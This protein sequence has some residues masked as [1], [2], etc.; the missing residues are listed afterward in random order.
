VELEVAV[1][2]AANKVEDQVD[3]AAAAAV[4]LHM[5]LVEDQAKQR[6]RH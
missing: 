3:Q 6:N 5:A 1:Q 4:A 2:A